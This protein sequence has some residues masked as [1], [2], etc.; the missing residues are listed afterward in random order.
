MD[1]LGE[2]D[3]CFGLSEPRARLQTYVSGQLSDLARKSVEPMALAANVLPTAPSRHGN[4][5]RVQQAT[6]IVHP[7]TAEIAHHEHALMFASYLPFV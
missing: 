6:R 5:A 7:A 3:D 1:F 4:A 2:F